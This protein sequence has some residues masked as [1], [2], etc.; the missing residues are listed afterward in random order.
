M[1]AVTPRRALVVI[2]LAICGLAQADDIYIADQNG[3]KTWN[4][5]PQPNE[6]VRWSGACKDGFIEGP[7]TLQWFEDGKLTSVNQTTYIA[8]KS[9]GY[10]KF[11]NLK[12]KFTYEGDVLNGQSHGY[13]EFRNIQTGMSYTGEFWEDN[14]H[15]LGEMVFADGRRLQGRWK[16]NKR[17]GFF[18]ETHTNGN[19]YQGL[20]TPVVQNFDGPATQIFPNGKRLN[21]IFHNGDVRADEP[22]QQLDTD[23]SVEI[24]GRLKREKK[25]GL[26]VCNSGFGANILEFLGLVTVQMNAYAA[27]NGY[28]F[29]ADP[30][31]PFAMI[32][33]IAGLQA[34]Q[35]QQRQNQQQQMLQVQLMQ[36]VANNTVSNVAPP[37]AAN[38]SAADEIAALKAQLAERDRLLATAQQQNVSP[39]AQQHPPA[40]RP[41]TPP[42]AAAPRASFEHSSG[43]ESDG[44]GGLIFNVYVE[45]TG[46]AV[47]TCDTRVT[48]LVWSATGGN[49]PQANHSDRRTSVV[50]AGRRQVVAGF[51]RVVANS[52]R[53]DTNC[54]RQ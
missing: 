5:R 37:A 22:C 43:Y 18:V 15:G 6:T 33:Q 14:L 35:R 20:Q 28:A 30:N 54:S 12:E 52:G 41:R 8:G 7:G 48:G 19:I 4:Q 50:Y 3:C 16:E 9:N 44:K 1:T 26:L 17:D 42:P 46:E 40:A 23:G 25:S 10:A 2:A 47:L 36:Q 13:G 51:S 31:N 53:Y 34:Q 11:S 24:K 32:G 49:N 45:N 39:P 21:A 38:S 27:A 29:H